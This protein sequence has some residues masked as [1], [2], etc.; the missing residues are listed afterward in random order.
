MKSPPPQYLYRDV[1]FHPP[2]ADRLADKIAEKI[3]QLTNGKETVLNSV[4][5]L[6]FNWEGH[7]KE[8]FTTDVDPHKRKFTDHLENLIRQEKFLRALKVTRRESYPNPAWEA[9]QRGK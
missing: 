9:Y 7:K 3:R 2:E 6:D 8:Q 1:V 5:N 4:N